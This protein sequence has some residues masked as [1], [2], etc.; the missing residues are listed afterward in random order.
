MSAVSHARAWFSS[1]MRMLKSG[2]GA[3]CVSNVSLA[4]I[5]DLWRLGLDNSRAVLQHPC[6]AELRGLSYWATQ[7]ARVGYISD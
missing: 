1:G 3:R 4:T 2:E 6:R 5:L 7:G